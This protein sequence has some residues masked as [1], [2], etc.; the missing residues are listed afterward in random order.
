MRR[1]ILL[2]LTFIFCL[3][4]AEVKVEKVLE[5]TSIKEYNQWVQRNKAKYPDLKSVLVDYTGDF[6]KY[7]PLK[8]YTISYYTE[9]GDRVHEEIIEDSIT[10]VRIPV[11]NDRILIRTPGGEFVTLKTVVKNTKGEIIFTVPYGIAYVGMDTYIEARG[12]YA[13]PDLGVRI[14]NRNGKV[15]N[16]LRGISDVDLR[17]C[18]PNDE[19]YTVFSG[20][21][22]VSKSLI[23]IDREGRE[24]WRR[25]GYH[26]S[27]FISKDGKKIGIQHGK[28]VSVYLEDGSFLHEYNPFDQI[29][30][31][32][33]FSEK[34]DRLVSGY[35]SRICYYDNETVNMLWRNDTALA[36]NKDR[37]RFLGIIGEGEKIWTLC[38]SH[39]L[40][41]FD[42]KG[43][44]LKKTNLKLGKEWHE[45]PA[46]PKHGRPFPKKVEGL[47]K[48]WS[49]ES[50]GNYL[51]I[52]KGYVGTRHE[53]LTRIIYKII[54]D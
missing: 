27:L 9:S 28:F 13:D 42:N 46:D 15:I 51:I 31:M 2:M 26:Y 22:D 23:L 17:F 11:T 32:N 54:S 45:I 16:T 33:A 38:W 40:Y 25:L 36:E 19:R 49:A 8:K 3:S 24:I 53:P 39:N 4:W 44:L 34:G 29:A 41:V 35:D 18:I 37:I 21:S 12:P 47:V 6:V 30:F 50:V 43:N 1:T 48:S 20:F 7:S 52:I 14:L 10:F 5:T